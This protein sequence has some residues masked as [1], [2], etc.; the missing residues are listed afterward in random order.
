MKI[1]N[2]EL[3]CEGLLS[4]DVCIDRADTF[5]RYRY[6]LMRSERISI[7][8]GEDSFRYVEYGM[9]LAKRG[10]K[11]KKVQQELNMVYM[12]FIFSP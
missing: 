5:C 4:I 7:G 9:C 12:H 10:L 8:F 11:V 3:N 6:F 2:S 1:G